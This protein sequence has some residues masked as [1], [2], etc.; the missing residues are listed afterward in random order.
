MERG[1]KKSMDSSFREN[2]YGSL[3]GD[4]MCIQIIIIK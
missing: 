1:E 4:E 2:E 3:E